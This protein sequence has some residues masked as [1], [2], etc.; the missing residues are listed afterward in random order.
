MNESANRKSVLTAYF[1][2]SRTLPNNTMNRCAAVR[3]RGTTEPCPTNALRGHTL[4]G[5]HARMRSPVLWAAVAIAHAQ[6]IVKIQALVRGWLVR[7]RLSYA[8]VGVLRRA[9]VSNDEDIIS[10]TEKDKVHPFD[11][12]SFEENGKIWWF[13]FNS[14]WTWC[15]RNVE[16][17][18]PYTKVPL[19]S[20]TRRR[21]RTVW[22]CKRRRRE[23]LPAESLV[24]EERLRH[25]MNILTQHFADYG[26]VDVHP[27]NFMRFSKADYITMFVLL[28]R[29]I[30]TVIPASD[31]FRLRVSRL[32]INRTHVAQAVQNNQFILQCVSLLLHIVTLYKDPYVITFSILSAFY[33]A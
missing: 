6:P 24:Y 33:R 8:G 14:L 12:F 17:S 15:M 31:P 19:S 9:D 11:F 16:P 28:Q 18:N 25:R 2:L 4:C 32:C 29:D 20:D 7:K 30:E 26:F 10:C 1:Q 21:L 23:E 5:R 27:E 13:E 22:G 3:R